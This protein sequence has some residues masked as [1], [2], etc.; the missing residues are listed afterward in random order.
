[1]GGGGLDLERKYIDEV[2]VRAVKPVAACR[3]RQLAL[4]PKK[5]NIDKYGRVRNIE[6]G[7]A[8]CLYRIVGKTTW[9]ELMKKVNIKWCEIRYGVERV[10]RRQ[11]ERKNRI[12]GLNKVA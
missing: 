3:P 1:V 4:P 12:C 10:T 9:I 6:R 5:E 8:Y 7:S 11:G 2:E